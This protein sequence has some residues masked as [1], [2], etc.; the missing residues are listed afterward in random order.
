[1][2]ERLVSAISITTA[3]LFSFGSIFNFLILPTFQGQTFSVKETVGMVL[4]PVA[5]DEKLS[6]L[7]LDILMLMVMPNND[8]INI[9]FALLFRVLY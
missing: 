9:I 3:H 5:E 1:V 2:D 8:I 7:Q 6:V 4:N